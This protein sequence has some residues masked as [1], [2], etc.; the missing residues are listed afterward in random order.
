MI[1]NIRV[2]IILFLNIILPRKSVAPDGTQTHASPNLGEHSAI[3][4]LW[5]VTT[6]NIGVACA[7]GLRWWIEYENTMDVAVEI[8]I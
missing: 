3:L 6:P 2:I 4:M 8:F 1:L 7:L 5:V